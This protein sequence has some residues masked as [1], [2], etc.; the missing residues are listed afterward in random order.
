MYK[1]CVVCGITYGYR[2]GWGCVHWVAHLGR[3]QAPHADVLYLIQKLQF[4][5]RCPITNKMLSNT[6]V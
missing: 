6:L 5:G 2:R 3:R 4:V 1:R